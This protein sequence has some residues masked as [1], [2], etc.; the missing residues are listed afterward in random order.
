MR[1]GLTCVAEYINI[2]KKVVMTWEHEKEKF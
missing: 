1:R 2:K